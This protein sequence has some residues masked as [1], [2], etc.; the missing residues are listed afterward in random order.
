VIHQS[1][2]NGLMPTGVV[3]WQ[4]IPAMSSL[5]LPFT[6]VSVVV[7]SPGYSS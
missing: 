2:F 3:A 1:K 7:G 5:S 6:G 4:F